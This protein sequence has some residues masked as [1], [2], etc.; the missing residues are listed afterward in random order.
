MRISK[1]ILILL[2]NMGA[3]Q[4]ASAEE[5]IE[6]R[7]SGDLSHKSL[8]F[9][10]G[11]SRAAVLVHQSGETYESWRELAVILAEHGV[12][13]LA[14]SSITPDDVLAAVRYLELENYKDILL[15]GAS[16]GGGAITQALAAHELETVTK[17]VLLAPSTGPAMT[18]DAIKKMVMVAKSDFYKSRAYT[19]FEEA[20]EPKILIEYEGTEH[21]Q[22]LLKG[23]HAQKVYHDILK[24]LNVPIGDG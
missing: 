7:V 17:V 1:L 23:V 9:K 22:A 6:L 10:S 12:T 5:M 19:S 24:F 4:I 14:L 2:M 21:G 18:S 8:L 20:S 11:L 3:L 16:L 15:I 13:S